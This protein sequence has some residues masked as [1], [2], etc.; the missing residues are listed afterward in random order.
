MKLIYD[1]T[2]YN[3]TKKSLSNL[4]NIEEQK[5]E[6]FIFL[7]STDLIEFLKA[8]DITDKK[9][10]EKEIEL[11]SIHNTTTNDGCLSLKEKGIINLQAA[12][13]EDTPLKRY[14]SKKDIHINVKDKFI[15]YKGN[16]FDISEKNVPKRFYFLSEEQ[17]YK[18]DVIRKLFDDFQVNGFLCHENILTYE[19]YTRY[20][21]EIL[22]DLGHY[23]QDSSIETD[24]VNDKNNKSYVIRYKQPLHYYR[25]FTFP[26]DYVDDDYGLTIDMFDILTKDEIK[27]MAIKWLIN[28][29]ISNIRHDVFESASYVNPKLKVEPEDVLDIM[30]EQ[31]YLDKYEIRNFESR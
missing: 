19:G 26:A 31:E 2:S 4:L 14:L 1:I 9:L 25:Y 7:K 27:V 21:P 20:R 8:F 30:T 3:S 23:L 6:E 18:N 22:L 5:I 10:L 13:I 24:W 12:V 17:T 16:K 28:K 15:L 11:V 29:S